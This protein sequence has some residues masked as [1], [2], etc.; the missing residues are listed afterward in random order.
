MTHWL[1]VTNRIAHCQKCPNLYTRLL[2]HDAHTPSQWSLLD[3]SLPC[4]SSV[5]LF[6][7]NMTPASLCIIYMQQDRKDESH[8]L[9]QVPLQNSILECTQGVGLAIHP[10]LQ[11]VGN[12]LKLA[13]GL[14]YSWGVRQEGAVLVFRQVWR[15][16]SAPHRMSCVGLKRRERGGREGGRDGKRGREREGRW[17]GGKREGRREGGKKEG[18]MEEG[19]KEG[20]REEGRRDGRGSEG[21][22]EG[23]RKEGWK[24]EV[25]YLFLNSYTDNFSA[26][27]IIT[28]LQLHV[29]LSH[30]NEPDDI[31]LN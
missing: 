18:G 31:M 2:F 23:R 13:A 3:C 26:I 30:A 5:H 1:N 14:L 24:R 22:R 10:P 11:C 29:H 16:P 12:G 15:L 4:T 8:G 7:P 19:G 21:G 6:T 25:L 17:K 9:L 28:T 27:C 20:G